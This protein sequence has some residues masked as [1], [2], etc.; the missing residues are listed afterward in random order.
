MWLTS[1]A[2]GQLLP[3]SL[4]PNGSPN[5]SGAYGS[6]WSLA[7]TTGEASTMGSNRQQTGTQ[8]EHDATATATA[9]WGL[10]PRFRLGPS[11]AD[12]SK[13]ADQA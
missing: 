6:C 4:E 2:R 1:T 7:R 13:R 5:A 3:Y 11:T 9:T 10:V 8:G 12:T